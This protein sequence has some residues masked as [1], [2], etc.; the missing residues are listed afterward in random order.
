ME[1]GSPG[2]TLGVALTQETHLL[3]YDCIRSQQIEV[4][5]MSFDSSPEEWGLPLGILF[6]VLFALWLGWFFWEEAAY[7]YAAATGLP[8]FVVLWGY[9]WALWQSPR[10]AHP[11]EQPDF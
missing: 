6:A 7:A 3:P 10:A 11:E 5:I 4:I 2:V 8:V 1:G 9:G